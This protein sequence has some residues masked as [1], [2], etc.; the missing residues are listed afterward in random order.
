MDTATNGHPYDADNPPSWRR[1]IA[2]AL[3]LSV[4]IAMAI[5]WFW[6]FRNGSSVAHPDEFDDPVFVTA[7]ESTCAA[8][9]EAILA[10][11]GPTTARNAIERAPLVSGGTAELE[12]MIAELAELDPPTDPKGADGVRQ[13]LD[14][15]DL[16]LDD[17][18]RYADILATGDDPPFLISG[19]EDGVR[20]T[21][22]LRTFAEVNDMPS[23]A[24]AGDV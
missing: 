15:Y 1:N 7:A 20:V 23:C 18:R 8:R 4:F 3:G 24:P 19:T 9:Q 16:Y 6:A 14:D 17:R 22:L 2:R 11:P 13:W 10:L 5:F 21:D 12:K